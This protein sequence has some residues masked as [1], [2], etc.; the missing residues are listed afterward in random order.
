MM[1]M[2]YSQAWRV[3]RLVAIHPVFLTP[4]VVVKRH[5]PHIRPKTGVKY[6][7]CDLNL[8]FIPADGKIVLVQDGE[9]RPQQQARRL[10]KESLRFAD[11]PLAKRGWAALVLSAIRKIGKTH[12]TLNEVYAFEKQMH[13]AYPQNNHVRPKIRQ[14]LQELRDLGY[15]EF[16]D[17]KGEYRMLR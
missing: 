4:A 16:L 17:N 11:V 6:Q 7:M 14:Q 9:V 5:K 12:F 2:Y 3:Q 1:L 10:F 15:I 8:S 13:G